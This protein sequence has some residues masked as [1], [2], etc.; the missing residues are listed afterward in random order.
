MC[1]MHM[2]SLIVMNNR[3][4]N[5][6]DIITFNLCI[7]EMTTAPMYDVIDWERIY[8]TWELPRGAEVEVEFVR[9][10]EGKEDVSGTCTAVFIY[11]DWMYWRWESKEDWEPLI[12]N[13]KFKRIEWNKFFLLPEDKKV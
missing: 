4:N 10:E 1:L 6:G 9:H 13:G 11:M 2:M 12:F 5:S 7:I 3:L 8:N